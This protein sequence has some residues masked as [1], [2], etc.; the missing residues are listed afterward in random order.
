MVAVLKK[1]PQCP[2]L[3]PEEIPE[4]LTEHDKALFFEVNS[5]KI[6]PE[7]RERILTPPQSFPYQK[8]VLAVHWHPEFVPIDL[9]IERLHLMFPNRKKELI[10]PTQHNEILSYKGYSGVEVDCYSRG[11]NQKVQ[12]L[13]HF[14]EKKVKDA[15]VLKAMLEHTQTYRSSQLFQFIR[16]ITLPDEEILQSAAQE[17]G[18]NEDLIR[19]V[20]I[21]VRKIESL[22]D[23]HMD[24]L[25]KDMLKNKLL[26]N[27]F[28]VL[29]ADYGDPLIDRVQSF[30]KAVKT[31]VKSNFSLQYFYRTSEIIEEARMHGAGIVVPHPEQFWPIL[32]AEYDV[33]GYE[34]WNPQ[35]QRYT[36]FLISVV[37]RKN[38]ERTVT[39]RSLLIFM[40]DD[41]HMGEKIKEP[42]FQ[43]KEKAGREIGYQPV[44]DDLNIRK[45]LIKAQVN[46]SSVI[47]EYRLRLA[48]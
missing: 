32:L 27:Y 3:V 46:I 33:D 45:R 2:G 8:E 15:H 19:F 26:R 34:V 13:L 16:S 35:S 9:A 7:Q 42:K 30:L 1:T 20:G 37:N 6:S 44:W 43:D 47:D 4:E 21:Y 24:S 22:L 17:T 23:A 36:D 18:A 28:D 29:R 48:S 41:T 25:P 39:Q 40:G 14:E 31:H 10:I 12:L 11:F 38:R 5:E